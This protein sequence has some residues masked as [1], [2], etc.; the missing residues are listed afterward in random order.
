MASSPFLREY[1]ALLQTY[2]TDYNQ[3]NHIHVEEN[4]ETIPAFFGGPYRVARFDN[5]QYFDFEGLRGRLLSSSY[6]PEP[7]QPGYNEML[8]ALRASFDR[9][10]QNNRV[11]FEYDT[12]LYYGHL[13]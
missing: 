10:Q 1:E 8:A 9:H 2:A 6:A 12:R 4:P 7:G 13:A 5:A 11:V 3:V